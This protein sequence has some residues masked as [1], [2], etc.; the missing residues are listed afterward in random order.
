MHKEKIIEMI[1]SI[2]HP[3]GK[4]SGNE[5]Y[6]IAQILDW[7]NYSNAAPFTLR[8]EQEFAK[9]MGVSY[10]IGHNSGTSTLHSCIAAASIGYGDE[11][12]MPAQS[13]LMNP[14]SVLHHNAIPIFVDIDEETFNIDP[15][16]IESK[17]TSKTKAIQVVHMH[18][19]PVDMDP[20]MELAKKYGLIVIEDTAQCML[21]TY[22]D[23]IAGTIGHTGS[24]SFETKKHLST[25][26]GGMV[27]TDIEEMGIK[28]R[29]N[30]GLGYKILGAGAPLKKVLPEQFQ[31]PDYKRHDTLGWNYR[32]NEITSALGLAQLER[33][34]ELVDKRQKCAEYFL[35]AISECDFIIPQKVP[36][37]YVNSYYTF[38]VRYLG[39]EM[40]D[41]TWKEFYNKYK[42]MGG[43]GFY[44]AVAVSYQEP[45]I[46]NKEYFQSGYLNPKK[47]DEF[48]NYNDGMCP[49][50]EKVQKQMMSFK[51]NYRDLEEAKNQALI[52]K[53]LIKTF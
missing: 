40:I 11:V 30:A 38:S 23:K 13:V 48:P 36:E 39:E 4:Y 17:I 35:D 34:D 15:S 33:I 52:L 49:I 46:R 29:K 21:G 37:G 53:K 32:L 3:K 45:A 5:L 18:G 25:G 8:F 2:L 27:T 51:T 24:W 10:A 19:L 28:V 43:D 41:K 6:Y 26:E 42:E 20:I 16:K 31:D 50:A 14:L 47:Y 44:G 22:K 7:D 9:K 12:I 1:D